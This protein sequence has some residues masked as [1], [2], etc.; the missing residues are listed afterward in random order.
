M[1]LLVCINTFSNIQYMTFV[2]CPCVWR[3]SMFIILPILAMAVYV[4]L[5]E[6]R[7]GREGGG[8]LR[9][10]YEFYS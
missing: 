10:V 9:S 8:V 5:G 6:G 3:F 4:W 1:I 7:E 2:D